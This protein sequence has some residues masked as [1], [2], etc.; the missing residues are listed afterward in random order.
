M[1]N[2]N[3]KTGELIGALVVSEDDEILL[4]NSNGIIIRI[5]AREVSVLGR[6]T[7]ELK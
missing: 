1:I 3:L 4:I 2:Q 5:E 7:Q 6:A